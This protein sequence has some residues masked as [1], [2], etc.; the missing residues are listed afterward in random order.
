MSLRFLFVLGIAC[1]APVFAHS[2]A[3]AP[4]ADVVDCEHPPENLARTLP[5][6]VAGVAAV[7]C[8]PHAQMIAPHDGW[9]WRY[10][11]SYFDR[12][13]IPAYSHIE[14]RTDAAGRYFTRFQAK[15]LSAA[16]IGKLHERF[17]QS[18]ATYPDS[19]APPRI[20]KL[21]ARNDQGHAVDAYFG[22][23]SK[24]EG[25]VAVC[26]PECAPEFFFLFNRQ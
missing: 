5:K 26:A 4:A 9:T 6:P 18:L 23:K 19:K 22:F 15:E 2:D 25:W 3:E 1:C 12:P 13:S 11:G 24:D 20:V 21:V 14:S 17:T 16:E 10:P 8:T 7:V